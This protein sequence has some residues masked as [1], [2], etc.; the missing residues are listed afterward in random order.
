[1]VVSV[2]DRWLPDCFCLLVRAQC[3]SLDKVRWCASHTVDTRR[4]DSLNVIL[5]KYRRFLPDTKLRVGIPFRHLL[6]LKTM[7]YVMI[8]FFPCVTDS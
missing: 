1:M 4:M 8:L 3:M 2:Y 6:D 7:H 5:T